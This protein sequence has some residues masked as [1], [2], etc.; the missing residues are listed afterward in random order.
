M[1]I[2]SLKYRVNLAGSS[3]ATALRTG[4]GITATPAANKTG[5]V[6]AAL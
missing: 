3:L 6:A 1:S 4:V 2:E 5:Q